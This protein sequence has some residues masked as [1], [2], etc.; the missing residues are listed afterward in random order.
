MSR[1]DLPQFAGV[2]KAEL[3]LEPDQHPSEAEVHVI[4]L[5]RFW[6]FALLNNSFF[7][8]SKVGFDEEVKRFTR[9]RRKQRSQWEKEK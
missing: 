7:G 4:W 5:V 6:K 9:D 1:S 2:R 3:S 8:I